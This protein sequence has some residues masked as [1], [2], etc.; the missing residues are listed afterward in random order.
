VELSR[1]GHNA[2]TIA[3][4]AHAFLTRYLGIIARV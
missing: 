4:E 2:V 1:H 3:K